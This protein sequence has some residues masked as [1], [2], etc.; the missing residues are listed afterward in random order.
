MHRADQS[1]ACSFAM[2]LAPD[3][4]QKCLFIP[5]NKIEKKKEKKEAAFQQLPVAVA[6]EEGWK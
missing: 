2:S 3:Y 5:K 6:E 4:K 1:T